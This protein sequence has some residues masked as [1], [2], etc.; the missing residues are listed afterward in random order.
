MEILESK[1]NKIVFVADM[2]DSLANSVRRYV[3]QVMVPAVD[4]LEISRND[5]PLYDE[6][7]AH[8]VGLVPLK[9]GKKSEGKLKLSAKKEGFVYSSELEGDFEIVYDKVPLT[10]L[11]KDQ[12]IEFVASVRLGKGSEHSKFSPGLMFY[13][14]LF[15]ITMDKSC[16]EEI[17]GIF[18]NV[19][20]KE[21]GNKIV[22]LDDKK[23]GVLDVCEEI[24][25]RNK[26]EIE[27]NPTG[28]VVI[29]LESFGQFEVK[30]IFKKSVDALKKDLNE[31]SKKL[32]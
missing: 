21:K 26:K 2:S 13:R 25:K 19:E 7:L 1:N 4:E 8:R 16:S 14:D 28:K 9:A 20:I 23:K 11:N 27:V 29:N 17:K 12:E 5:S 30:D 10:L 32:K 18:P 6:T 15:E 24:S 31:V 3:N 22:I